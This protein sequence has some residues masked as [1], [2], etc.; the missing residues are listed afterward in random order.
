MNSAISCQNIIKT[1]STDGQLVTALNGIN[2][3]IGLGELMMLV[4]PSGC[5]KTTLISIIAGILNQDSGQCLLFGE[6]F[7]ALTNTQQLRFRAHNIGFVFQAYNLLPAL[8]AIENVSVPLII[9][10]TKRAVAEQK[11]KEILEQ[12]GLSDR[13]KALPAQLSGGQQ[14]RVAIARALVH[15]PRLIVCDEPTSALDHKSGHIIM[16]LLKSIA[17][18]HDR[19]LV[20]V[21]HDARIFGFA[22]RIAE[23]DDGHI[24][25]ISTT[26]SAEAN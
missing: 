5:G 4:G 6:N 10:G 8:N 24:I 7:Q 21:T 16:S 3:E 26:A 18:Q 22:D 11:A 15:S 25:K 2:I 20:I 17:L 23:M 13:M 14:Q 12:M 19:A 1:Y 9:T